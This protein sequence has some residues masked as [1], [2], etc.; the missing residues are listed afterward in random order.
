MTAVLPPEL[1]RVLTGYQ[2]WLDRQPLSPHTRRAYLGRVRH[3]GEYLAACPGDYGDPIEDG[4]ARKYAARD[5]KTHLKT[6]RKARPSTVNL[7][8]AAIDHF[9][10][11]LGG[12]QP[13]VPREELPQQAPRALEAD[14]Q[15]RFLRAVERADSARDRALALLLFFTGLRVGECAAL[16]VEDVAL[17]ARKG[18]VIIRSGKGDA[19]REVPL[20]SE[21]RTA[22][23][24]WLEA[25]RTRDAG[26]EE[27]ALFLNRSGSRLSARMMELALRRLGREAGLELS[28]H[29][30]RHTCLTNLVR[31]GHDLVLVADVAG[32]KRLETTR[33]YSLPT[34]QDRARAMESLRIDY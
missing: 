21:A 32:H 33:R 15:R 2:A 4:N 14:Q 30:L 22:L 10:S 29:T 13:H 23:A 16:D 3:Y 34:Q 8:L 12:V 11:F 24:A 5:Y 19:Y 31:G 25:R 7:A 18:S 20:N 27:P 26:R 9:Y 6:V 1:R 17:S 28:P